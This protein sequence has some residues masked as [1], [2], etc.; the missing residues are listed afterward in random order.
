MKLEPES[1]WGIRN[2]A[3]FYLARL[4]EQLWLKPLI[5]CFLSIVAAFIASLADH[6]EFELSLPNISSESI[7]TLLTT[8]ATSMLTIAV[9]SVGSMLSAYASASSTATPRSFPLIISDD[10][11]QNALSTFIGAFIFS[12]VALVALLN[13]FYEKPGRFALFVLTAFVFSLVILSFVRWVDRIARLG[14]LGNTIAKIETA[15]DMALQTQ[16]QLHKLCVTRPTKTNQYIAVFSGVTRHIQNL[17]DIAGITNTKRDIAI[18]SDEVGYVQNISFA[19]LQNL[20]EQFDCTV[21][22]CVLPGAFVS[23][24]KPLIYI[25][26]KNSFEKDVI[27]KRVNDAFVIDNQRTFESDPRFGLIALSQIASR[28]LSPAVNDAG[29]AI[30]IITVFVRLFVRTVQANEDH[31]DTQ[32]KYDRV[33]IPSISFNDMLDDAFTTIARDG[34]SSA[35]VIIRQLKALHSLALLGNKEMTQ[36]AKNQAHLTLHYA[37]QSLKLPEELKRVKAVFKQN[38]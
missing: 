30:D 15:A 24:G 34:A 20:A 2:T 36:A 17:M 1:L 12:I 23:L 22:V 31:E 5:S 27:N 26:Q 38:F 13:D 8:I 3:K 16:M 32:I 28:A 35:N 29:T 19:K 37:Q 21:T 6:I 11:S 10:V 33:S 7:E 9:F 25:T 4:R 14:R 18:F